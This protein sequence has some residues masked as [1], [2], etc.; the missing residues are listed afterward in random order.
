MFGLQHEHVEHE[1]ST[2]LAVTTAPA[3]SWPNC[4]RAAVHN[5]QDTKYPPHIPSNPASADRSEGYDY[6]KKLKNG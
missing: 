1:A 2:G 4:G 3:G 6:I 5:A